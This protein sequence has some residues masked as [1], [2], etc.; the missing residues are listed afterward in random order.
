MGPQ[1]SLQGAGGGGCRRG[2]PGHHAVRPDQGPGIKVDPK[3]NALPGRVHFI[4]WTVS[5]KR[6]TGSSWI[7]S[8]ETCRGPPVV[9]GRGTAMAVESGTDQFHGC[10][11]YGNIQRDC[12]QPV[13]KNR[14]KQG[15]K[16]GKNKRGSGERE[17]SQSGAPTTTPRSTAMLS[18]S[19]SRSSERK[20]RLK[21]LRTDSNPGCTFCY[22]V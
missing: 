12:P 9:S 14:P 20:M 11:A 7:S 2:L 22:G 19:N 13:Q 16:K 8:R 5:R 4:L 6:S 18:V 3:D 21:W 1:A 10:K 17:L 15:K